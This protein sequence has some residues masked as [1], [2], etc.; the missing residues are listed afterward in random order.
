MN[1]AKIISGTKAPGFG[2]GPALKIISGTKAP[3]SGTHVHGG[4]LVPGTSKIIGEEVKVFRICMHQRFVH[5]VCQEGQITEK[6]GL[7]D[8]LI[9]KHKQGGQGGR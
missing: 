6:A 3:C 1:N 7:K 5:W 9:K 2:I 4:Q 8:P